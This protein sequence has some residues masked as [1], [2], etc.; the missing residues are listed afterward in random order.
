[1]KICRRDLQKAVSLNVSKLFEGLPFIHS[2]L[3][4]FSRGEQIFLKGR[5]VGSLYVVK[6]MKS[7]I[8]RCSIVTLR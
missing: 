2:D 4:E 8:L 3:K 1:M 5:D 7:Y 6:V